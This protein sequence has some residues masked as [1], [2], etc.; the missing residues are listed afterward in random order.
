[1]VCTPQTVVTC[2]PKQLEHQ[3]VGNNVSTR[4]TQL[5]LARLLHPLP[6]CLF[7]FAL[8]SIL[9]YCFLFS[10][11]STPPASFFTCHLP[12]ATFCADNSLNFYFILF[13]FYLMPCICF[14]LFFFCDFVVFSCF[15]LSFSAFVSS[16]C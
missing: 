8:Y 10:F 16:L 15:L 1:M 5:S 6:L 12:L 2:V 14:I 9:I 13:S 7:Y 4:D 3:Q 11:A